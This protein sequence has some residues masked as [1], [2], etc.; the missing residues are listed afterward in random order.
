MRAVLSP[1]RLPASRAALNAGALPGSGRA[2]T[3][4]GGHEAGAEINAV[5]C[6][7]CMHGIFLIIYGFFGYFQGREGAP[8]RG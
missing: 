2:G 3:G 4:A 8:G 1:P 7:V 6:R 5:K